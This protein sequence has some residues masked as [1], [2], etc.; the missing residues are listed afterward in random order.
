MEYSGAI[1]NPD[2]LQLCFEDCTKFKRKHLDFTQGK[3]CQC[4]SFECTPSKPTKNLCG[5]L[6]RENVERII[7][8]ENPKRFLHLELELENWRQQF[9]VNAFLA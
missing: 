1:V 8:S 3:K 7:N 6:Q 5:A 9:G 4:N 2:Y